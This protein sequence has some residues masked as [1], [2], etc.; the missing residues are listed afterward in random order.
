MKNKTNFTFDY[1]LHCEVIVDGFTESRPAPACS[2]PSDP[3]Y[4]D[5]GDDAEFDD[6]EI[7]I[8]GVNLVDHLPQQIINN[9]IEEI[10][11]TGDEY[12]SQKKYYARYDKIIEDK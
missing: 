8:N 4:S 9:I 10:L 6:F 5:C 2:N 12:C 7:V 1:D 3:S 11:V